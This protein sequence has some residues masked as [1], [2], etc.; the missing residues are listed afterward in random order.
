[1]KLAFLFQTANEKYAT[2]YPASVG[3]HM[4]N[5]DSDPFKDLVPAISLRENERGVADRRRLGSELASADRR[6]H[7]VLRRDFSSPSPPQQLHSAAQLTR[8]RI[9]TRVTH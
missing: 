2:D 8:Q 1:M 3:P 4:T 6:L 5:T 9:E 7:D